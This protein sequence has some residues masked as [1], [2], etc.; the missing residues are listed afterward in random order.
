LTS[1]EDFAEAI[2]WHQLL[3]EAVVIF[4]GSYRKNTILYRTIFSSYETIASR[5]KDV[6]KQDKLISI[7]TSA[8]C[9]PQKFVVKFCFIEFLEKTF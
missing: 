6:L 2:T 8:I 3:K 7:H 5:G 4:C 1:D 9:H